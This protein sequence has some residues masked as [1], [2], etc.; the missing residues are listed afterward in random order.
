[1]LDFILRVGSLATELSRLLG[2]KFLPENINKTPLGRSFSSL[3]ILHNNQQYELRD[4]ETIKL[5]MLIE[6]LKRLE[7]ER[8]DILKYSN[9]K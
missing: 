6:D 3:M 1:M 4:F 7:Q 9:E 2:T 5:S 8:P